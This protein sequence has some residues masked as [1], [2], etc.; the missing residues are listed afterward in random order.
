MLILHKNY[1]SKN[2]CTHFQYK[3]T[4]KTIP[5]GNASA[6]VD[7]K[8]ALFIHMTPDQYLNITLPL[9]D[10]KYDVINLD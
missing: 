9:A 7:E 5:I 4:S 6:I 1:F 3:F 10:K 2:E 8:Q